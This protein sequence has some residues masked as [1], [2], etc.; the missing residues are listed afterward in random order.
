MSRFDDEFKNTAERLENLFI[1]M[2]YRLAEC[3]KFSEKAMPLHDE[4]PCNECLYKGR[5]F[6]ELCAPG[7]CPLLEEEEGK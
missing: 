6:I 1:E 2:F 5:G 7:T 3:C 4:E